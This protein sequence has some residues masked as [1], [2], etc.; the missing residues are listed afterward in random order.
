MSEGTPMKSH[1]RVLEA[2][3]DDS[4]RHATMGAVRDHGPST[5]YKELR[6]TK[7]AESERNSLPQGRAHQFIILYQVVSTEHTQGTL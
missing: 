5:L 7:D 6:T 1:Q 4:N 2:E 3:Q